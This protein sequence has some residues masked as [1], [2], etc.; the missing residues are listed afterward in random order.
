MDPER[1]G[2]YRLERK[3]GEGGMGVVYAA[4]D[5]RLE[6]RV[7]LKQIRP[8]IANAA[9]RERFRGEARAVA[10]LDHPAIVRIHDLLET[11]DGDW[12][13]LQFVEG[14][15]LARRL[16]HGPLPPAQVAS[17][18]RDVLGALDAAHSRGLLHRDLKTE[19]VV[20]SPS[21]H[22]LV[23]DFGLAKLYAPGP[24]GPPAD[25]TSATHGIAAAGTGMAGIVGTFRAM[26]PEQAGGLPLDLP[27][28]SRDTG[29][30]PGPDLHPPA[31]P[32]A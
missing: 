11:P 1:I 15:T 30:H 20:L 3:L 23:L 25:A 24:G 13:V 16:R 8:E 10:Q 9:N 17:V 6:R 2:P 28:P 7:A 18:A 19:N 21:G 12:L 27:V 32:R 29:R 4:W 26:S 5:E 22:A 14:P 31:G